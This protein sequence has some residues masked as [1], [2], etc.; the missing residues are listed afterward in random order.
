MRGQTDN[1]DLGLPNVLHVVRY[2][3]APM[4]FMVRYPSCQCS[5][6]YIFLQEAVCIKA[7]LVHQKPNK[8]YLHSNIVDLTRYGEHWQQLYKG[9]HYGTRTMI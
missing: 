4:T 7:W 9:K 8:F 6:F 3:A 1:A 2:G 5:T